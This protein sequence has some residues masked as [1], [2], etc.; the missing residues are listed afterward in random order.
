MRINSAAAMIAALLLSLAGCAVPPDVDPA[1][2]GDHPANPDAPG[3]PIAP[4][5]QTLAIT[6]HPS[7]TTLP[8][9]AHDRAG[10]GATPTMRDMPGME[11]PATSP[12]AAAIYTCP[13]HPEV[14][15]DRPGNCPICG[16]KLVEKRER[17]TK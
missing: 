17:G 16:M 8:A 10:P 5:S 13:M 7:A 1:T 9:D 11:M 15:A 6:A 2:A 14:H 12:A 4:P 3:T